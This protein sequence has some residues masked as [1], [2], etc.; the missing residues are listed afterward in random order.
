MSSLDI[1]QRDSHFHL[2]E[3]QFVHFG[4]LTL[5]QSEFYFT[6]N[7]GAWT[8]IEGTSVVEEEFA[9]SVTQFMNY[10]IHLPEHVPEAG[11]T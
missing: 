5:E 1:A 10:R 4:P 8:R 7:A 3:F 2:L 6:R 11:A 9:R